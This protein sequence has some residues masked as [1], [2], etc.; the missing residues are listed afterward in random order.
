MPPFIP[1]FLKSTLVL[2][3]FVGLGMAGG[4]DGVEFTDR[5]LLVATLMIPSFALGDIAYYGYRG[6]NDRDHEYGHLVHEDDLGPLY[7][8]LAGLASA[9]GN[10]Q[11]L[12]GRWTADDYY[13]MWT[14]R[15]ADQYGGVR[16]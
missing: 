2:L 14:E 7:L 8:P 11:G 9:L 15:M 6:D 12:R 1:E 4:V 5:G 16:R 10:L 13:G 3:G